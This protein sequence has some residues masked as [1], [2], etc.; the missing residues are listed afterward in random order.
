MNYMSSSRREGVSYRPWAER[1]RELHEERDL[2][3]PS[4][5]EM[6]D[7]YHKDFTYEEVLL[8]SCTIKEVRS[9]YM[10]VHVKH[11]KGE[12]SK[13]FRTDLQAKEFFEKFPEL[14]NE[15]KL[16]PLPTHYRHEKR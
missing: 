16:K 8:K 12:F 15:L 2:E 10:E 13:S 3:M 5:N 11:S 9:V 6:A 4:K 14:R 7:M 1:V